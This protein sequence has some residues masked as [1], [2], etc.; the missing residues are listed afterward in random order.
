MKTFLR[1]LVIS[2]LLASASGVSAQTTTPVV[3]QLGWEIGGGSENP[4]SNMFPLCTY[5]SYSITETFISQCEIQGGR[6]TLTSL[7][8]YY[9]SESSLTGK[10]NCTIWLM[11]TNFMAFT[12]VDDIYELSSDAVMVYSGALNCN[13][14]GWNEFVFSTPFEYNGTSNLLLIIEDN[15][16]NYSLG[17]SF[18]VDAS[19]TQ[20]W[21]DNESSGKKTLVWYGDSNNPEFS[22]L[23]TFQGLKMIDH[24]RGLIR[25]NGTKQVSSLPYTEG[26]DTYESGVFGRPEGW[27]FDIEGSYAWHVSSNGFGGNNFA[28]QSGHSEPNGLLASLDVN[29]ARTFARNAYTPWFEPVGMADSVR[30]T[31]WMYNPCGG[32]EDH[33][34]GI[35]V[36]PQPLSYYPTATMSDVCNSYGNN[37]SSVSR[38]PHEN[39]VCISVAFPADRVRTQPFRIKLAPQAWSSGGSGIYIDDV[40][41]EPVYSSTGVGAGGAVTF[42]NIGPYSSFY[43]YSLSESIIK[44]AEMNGGR[45]QVLKSIKYYYEGPDP[46]TVKDNCTIWLQPT[47]LEDFHDASGFVG[48]EFGSKQVYSGSMN[49]VPGW[50][51]F[52][53]DEPYYYDGKSN[54]MV[55]VEDRSGV[56]E[57]QPAQKQFAIAADDMPEGMISRH[58]D[59]D[60]IDWQT[61]SIIKRYRPVMAFGSQVLKEFPY[62]DD[63]ESYPQGFEN[64][65]DWATRVPETESYSW[66]V[67]TSSAQDGWTGSGVHSGENSLK[68]RYTSHGDAPCSI[69]SPWFNV[70]KNTEMKV[71]FWLCN[72]ASSCGRYTQLSLS[73]Q[74]LGDINGVGYLE[75]L[76][77]YYTTDAMSVP[78]DWRQVEFTLPD[79]LLSLAGDDPVR[80][81]FTVQPGG[82]S[83]SDGLT[84]GLFMDDLCITTYRNNNPGAVYEI[85]HGRPYVESFEGITNIEDCGWQNDDGTS[86]DT[87]WRIATRAHDSNC[88]IQSAFDGRNFLYLHGHNNEN[89]KYR[90]VVSPQF[91]LG[92]HNPT[93][94]VIFE[95]MYCNPS[96]SGDIDGLGAYTNSHGACGYQM[97]DQ[98]GPIGDILAAHNEWTKFRAAF[99]ASYFDTNEFNLNM[100]GYLKYGYGM[101]VDDVKVSIQRQCTITAIAVPGGVATVLVNEVTGA[102]ETTEGV[103][104]DNPNGNYLVCREG[105]DVFLR[106]IPSE[107]YEFVYWYILYEGFDGAYTFRYPEVLYGVNENSTWTAVFRRTD[108]H[109]SDIVQLNESVCVKRFV[110][111]EPNNYAYGRC[112]DVNTA[113]PLNTTI[114]ISAIPNEGYVFQQWSDGSTQ[115]PRLFTFDE[116]HNRLTAIFV[117]ASDAS[118]GR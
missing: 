70:P 33:Y 36:M 7:S 104:Q 87:L 80:F 75:E 117:P 101:F 10:D 94:S 98:L 4:T 53:F 116:E 68:C 61:A 91:R 113:L 95:F 20:T 5:Y 93:D 45:P 82:G 54:L 12:S 111:I 110:W 57:Y 21:W 63:F 67:N 73:C 23:S 50:N 66:Y 81:K 1:F 17:R 105:S 32:N 83:S 19:H 64:L 26:F 84:N 65:R 18:A 34:T 108:N 79:W 59:L 55:I 27:Q 43:K 52:V 8:L 42:D 30:V 109:V 100:I 99:P 102:S 86:G 35:L 88:P 13:V 47:E 14:Q 92:D 56:Y 96:W 78:G 72:P 90:Y 24:R 118:S 28:V 112:T 85:S 74:N 71:S 46:V 107:G 49:C 6:Q 60:Y 77:P 97:E 106:A 25:L 48:W 2:L 41:V 69:Y 38:S 58:N 115:N 29:G 39:W 62:T 89:D 22:D 76:T 15:S 9:A 40:T 37:I 103:V 44:A 3:T 51:E 11:P 31:F 16:G 114:E